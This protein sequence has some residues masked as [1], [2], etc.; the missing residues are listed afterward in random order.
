MDP[1]GRCSAKLLDASA[2]ANLG[3]L[4]LGASSLLLR[5]W[6]VQDISFYATVGGRIV[7]GD[8]WLEDGVE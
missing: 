3:D 5:L 2:I 6:P 8:L 7:V 1:T 4:L